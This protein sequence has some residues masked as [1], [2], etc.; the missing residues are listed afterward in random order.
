MMKYLTEPQQR[1]LLKA[2]R[3]QACPLAQRDYHWMAAMIL[4]GMR[5]HEFSRLTVPVVKKALASGWLFSDKNH[6]KGK[7]RI[8]E[9][10]VTAHLRVHLLALVSMS[11]AEGAVLL[12]L[13]DPDADCPLVWGRA[14]DGYA[15]AL[16]VRSYQARMKVWLL[17]AG[18]DER[19]SPHALRHTRGMNIIRNHRGNNAVK[20][21]QLALNHTSLR[22]TTIYTHLSREEL[23]RDL[24]LVDGRGRIGKADARRLAGV[25]V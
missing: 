6:C 5:V 23:E 11:E 8:N 12:E 15:T 7:R 4:L 25:G 10:C 2:A 1:E 24:Q 22:S 14:V 17:A 19:F 16:S 21:A 13:A 18:L 20:V 9:Y 3:T